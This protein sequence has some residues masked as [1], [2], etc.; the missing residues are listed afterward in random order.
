MQRSILFSILLKRVLIS[1]FLLCTANIS[2]AADV[3]VSISIGQPGFYGH[4]EI[5]DYP[6]PQ[7]RVIYKKPIVVH[8]HVDVYEP[9]YLRV[10]PGHAKNWPRYCSHY[11]ACSQ[12]VYFVQDSWYQH[13]YAPIYRER[14]HGSYDDRQNNGRHHEQHRGN[15]KG[16]RHD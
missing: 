5:G 7:P 10:P 14:H 1:A 11:H 8:R 2:T 9:V 15:G 3:G 6:Y 12:P 13:E 4:I 16:K